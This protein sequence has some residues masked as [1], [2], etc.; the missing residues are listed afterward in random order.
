MNKKSNSN[1]SLHKGQ[2][3]T[4][5][6]PWLWVYRKTLYSSQISNLKITVIG[7]ILLKMFYTK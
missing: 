2:E 1:Q 5:E 3:T 6:K 4:Q 7:H